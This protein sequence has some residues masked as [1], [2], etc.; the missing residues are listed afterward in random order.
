MYIGEFSDERM[1]LGN[2]RRWDLSGL[3]SV[4]HVYVAEH[5]IC[6]EPA[7]GDDTSVASLHMADSGRMTHEDEMLWLVTKVLVW[8]AI[9]CGCFGMAMIAAY[10]ITAAHAS[11]MRGAHYYATPAGT[12]CN[13]VK[14]KQR[15]YGFT[16]VAQA[17][18]YAAAQ[19]ILVTAQQERQILSCLRH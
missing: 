5:P 11:K 18:A 8:I 3:W 4:Q 16:S 1:D 13:D 12:T 15:E 7:M 17:K 10:F 19:G 14:Q 6:R 9:M 2:N